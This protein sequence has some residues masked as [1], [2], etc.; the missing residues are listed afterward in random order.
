M[1]GMP[2]MDSMDFD[3]AD[4]WN[5]KKSR[6][7]VQHGKEKQRRLKEKAKKDKAA[8]TLNKA[9]RMV[10]KDGMGRLG[11]EPITSRKRLSI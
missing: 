10:S 9:S 1:G 3:F 6:D 4:A 8:N 11:N 2:N 7:E 5:A